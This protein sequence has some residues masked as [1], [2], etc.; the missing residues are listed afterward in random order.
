MGPT[1]EQ[2]DRYLDRV[3]ALIREHGWI[4]QSVMPDT[5]RLEPGFSYT[6]GLADRQLPDLCVF[7]LPEAVAGEILNT[8]ARRLVS[9]EQIGAGQ[10][11][12][13][14]V[15]G[16]EVALCEVDAG[17]MGRFRVAR[18]LYNAPPKRML[19]LLWPDQRGN[20]PT[21]ASF[22]E[23]SRLAQPLLCSRMGR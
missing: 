22:D 20:F 13:H 19:Q 7:G 23:P 10:R 15:E 5:S 16:F 18:A 2:L 1:K 17:E 12:D 6:V 4:V 9:G 3:R 21:E 8:V 14:V 11:L